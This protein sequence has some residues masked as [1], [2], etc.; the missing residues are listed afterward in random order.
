MAQFGKHLFG[1]SL[2]GKSNSF[3]GTYDTRVIDAGQDFDGAI[4]VN[5]KHK[6]PSTSY[7][8]NEIVTIGKEDEYSEADKKESPVFF[9][10]GNISQAEEH[11]ILRVGASASTYL[12]GKNIKVIHGAGEATITVQEEHSEEVK[13]YTTNDTGVLELKNLPE[14]KLANYS[15]TITATEDFEFIQLDVLTTE[16]QGLVRA[17]TEEMGRTDYFLKGDWPLGFQSEAME[18]HD[19][20]WVYTHDLDF[21][22]DGDKLTATTEEYLGVRYIQIKLVLLTTDKNTSPSVQ[23]IQFYS[24]DL[25]KYRS[26]GLWQASLEMKNIASDAGVTFKKVKKVKWIEKEKE[27]SNIDIHSSSKNG[28]TPPEMLIRDDSR[29]S[30]LTAKYILKHDGVSY[31]IPYSRISLNEKDNGQEQTAQQGSV[32][33]G[34]VNTLNFGFTNTQIDN[35]AS[36]EGQQFYPR[37]AKS[38][39]IY[40]EFFENAS[41]ITEGGS[42]LHVIENPQP[43]QTNLIGNDSISKD[44]DNLYVRISFNR[45]QDMST[46]VFDVFNL[47]T[48]LKYQSSNAMHN[49]TR[50]LSALDGHELYNQIGEGRRL[51]ERINNSTFDWPNVNQS[52]EVNKDYILNSEK[53]VEINYRPKYLN[54]VYLG[55]FSP[56][57][58][59]FSFTTDYPE[60]YEIHSQV[61]AK[62]PKASVYEVDEDTLYW[63]FS[64]D[65]GTVNFPIATKRELTTQFTPSLL[66]DKQ[67]RYKLENGWNDQTF[68]VPYSM[69]LEE[70]ADIT[71]TDPQEM[72]DVNP[73]VPLYEDKSDNNIPKV[74]TKYELTLPNNTLNKLVN[75]KFSKTDDIITNNSILN[76]KE[77]DSIEAWIDASDN[78]KY[79]EWTSE[80]V[81]FN[82]MINY[83]DKEE[84]YLRTQNSAYNVMQKGNHLVS[85]SKET[86]IEIAARYSVNVEDLLMLNDRKEI[87]YRNETV[88]I[89]GGY[90]LPDIVPGLIFEGD[91]P[92]KTE[93][94]P[95]SV[96]R[97]KGN[98]RLP[99]EV[100]VPGSDDEEGISYTLTESD[101]ET[102]FIKRGAVANGRDRIPVSNV[103]KVHSVAGQTSGISYI[104]ASDV[105]GDY[106]V[107]DGHI[108]WSPT[109]KHS[110]EPEA[111][112]YYGVT[113]TRGVVDTLRIVYSSDYI[114]HMSQDRMEAI[115]IVEDRQYQLD[116]REDHLIQ[117]DSIEDMQQRY[118]E[119]KN[120]RY[121]AENSNLW[122]NTEIDGNK[123]RITMNGE[124]PNVNWYPKINTGFYYLND[125]EHYLY[126]RPTET[127]FDD[128]DIPVIQN[129]EYTERGLKAPE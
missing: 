12:S 35:W 108:D 27:Q 31:G 90:Y 76:G 78:Y 81:I 83:N 2:F 121:V 118:P 89:P 112:E 20:H 63:H 44:K 37:N 101:T 103:I 16:I 117:L 45:N 5:L 68:K 32:F 75:L 67:Y 123:L 55:I 127:V 96:R 91:H 95:G 9:Y 94:I 6:L 41:D 22:L 129:V 33:F 28:T 104:E 122:V 77:N 98:I 119:L 86:A 111:G 65:G 34:P 84:P 80:E 10:E 50:R 82:G 1:T 62:R 14:D 26:S 73:D 114:E 13:T 128:K 51:I 25:S 46:P 39:S 19:A 21:T 66:Q 100:L 24:G 48:K 30:E 116:L 7:K 109:F 88:I 3:I 105:L 106:I 79:T 92:Y 124:D 74:L 54:Q 53:R 71:M 110:K 85:L 15:I 8:H 69:T 93:V 47:M 60:E 115:P 40:I 97:T 87:F 59:M 17:T 102:I 18:E 57:E 23:E 58:Q 126:S 49:S 70:A 11:T 43:F 52:L 61:Y 56:E 29:W 113:L 4:T 99:S 125:K 38:S 120:I 36:F 42:P 64:Y 107:K 72:I